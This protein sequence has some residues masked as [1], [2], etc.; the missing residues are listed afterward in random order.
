MKFTKM[1]FKEITIQRTEHDV[2][3]IPIIQK[4]KTKKCHH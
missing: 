4:L 1:G 2:S 3:E